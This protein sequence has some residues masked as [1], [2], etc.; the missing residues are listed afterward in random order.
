MENEMMEESPEA[1]GMETNAIEYP[2]QDNSNND[3]DDTPL[4][5]GEG[6]AVEVPVDDNNIPMEDDDDDD[7]LENLISDQEPIVDMAKVTISSH[8]DPVYAVACTTSTVDGTLRIVS[9]GGD[10]KAFWHDIPAAAVLQ[11]QSTPLESHYQFKDSVSSVASNSPYVAF[12]TTKPPN[13]EW[14]AVGGLDGSVVLFG[15]GGKVLPL[16]GPSADIEWLCWHPK[17]GN[18]LLVGSS[19]ATIWMFHTSLNKCLQVF[20]GHEDAVTCGAFSADGKVAL[21][22]SADGTLRIWAPKTGKSKHVFRFAAHDGTPPPALTC[23]ATHGGTDQQLVM[24]GGEDGQAHVCHVA[25]KKQVASLRHYDPTV[26]PQNSNNNME[27]EEVMVPSGVEAVG[28]CKSNPNWCATGGM[29]GVLKIWDL[30]NQGQ[31]R[32]ACRVNNE[33]T[34]QPQGDGITKLQWHP[35]LPL[36][37]TATCRGE[38]H[39]WDARNGQRIHTLTGHADVINDMDVSFTP[40]VGTAAAG[41][42]VVVT[43]SDDKTVKVFQLDID[44]VMAAP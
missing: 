31:C 40:G 17:G 27:D 39:L 22:A 29:D 34:S 23:L 41:N 35:T 42:A 3:V 15:P 2:E 10:D 44:A 43:A 20:V 16:E 7:E 13:P 1:G 25:N 21:S 6:D 9:G 4:F 37:V 14:M 19:D 26:Q 32:H 5:V 12:D 24:V 33:N 38:L 28:F 18:V 11:V 30:A 36:V 8:S